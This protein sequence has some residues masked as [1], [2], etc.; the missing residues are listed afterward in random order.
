MLATLQKINNYILTACLSNILNYFLNFI[1]KQLKQSQTYRKVVSTIG[2]TFFSQPFE[3]A[4]KISNHA[5][6]PLLSFSA[7][8]AILSH[9]YTTTIKNQEITTDISLPP[10]SQTPIQ[11]FQLIMTFIAK[12]SSSESHIVISWHISSISLSLEHF[13]SLSLTFVTLTFED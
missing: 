13:S 1:L 7:N 8:E 5:L 3:S 9:S 12:I 4:T 6:I 11:I 2:R 10:N